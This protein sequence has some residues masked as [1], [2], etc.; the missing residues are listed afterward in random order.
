MGMFGGKKDNFSKLENTFEHFSTLLPKY[1]IT[2]DNLFSFS[3]RMAA[4]ML[5][6]ENLMLTTAPCIHR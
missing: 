1:D 3:S 4:C 5:A 6:V 2:P